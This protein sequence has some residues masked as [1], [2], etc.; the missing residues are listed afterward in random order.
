MKTF[1]F[2]TGVKLHNNPNGPIGG[3]LSRNSVWQIPFECADVPDGSIF[4][5]ASNDCPVPAG[6]IR[7]E[8]KPGS[9]ILSK[10][11][12]FRLPIATKEGN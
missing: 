4:V 9:G 12:Y 2:D 10:F 7:R 11:A 3:V 5:F 1:F 8:I 6:H